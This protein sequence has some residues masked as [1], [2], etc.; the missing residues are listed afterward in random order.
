MIPRLEFGHPLPK[1]RGPVLQQKYRCEACHQITSNEKRCM[2]CG[3]P[4]KT[5][6]KYPHKT[7]I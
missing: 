3:T 2:G 6:Q 1:P 4:R 5:L 7:D